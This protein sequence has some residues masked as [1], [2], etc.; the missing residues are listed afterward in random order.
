[1]A[2][3]ES[4]RQPILE[5][6]IRV[7]GSRGYR[8][9]SVAS[10]VTEA[11]ASRATFYKHFAGRED[12]FLAAYDSAVERVLATIHSQCGPERPWRGRAR[13]GLAAVVD[14]FARDPALARVAVVEVVATGEAGRQRQRDTIGRLAHLL[15]DGREATSQPHPPNTSLMAAGA[16]LGLLF[17]ELQAGQVSRLPQL[18]PDL[19]FAMLVPFLGPR[20]T[21]REITAA[22]PGRAPGREGAGARRAAVPGR[23]AAQWRR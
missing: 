14:L 21:V 9:A 3:G 1:M 4:R 20:A 7:A 23:G 15:E 11:R 8:A 12:C 13:A 16:V 5:A 6:M 2:G 18:L 17:D 19:E 10:V 22:G